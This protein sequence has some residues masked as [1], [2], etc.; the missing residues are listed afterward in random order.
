[1]MKEKIILYGLS[2]DIEDI[3][4][5]MRPCYQII[6][7]SDKN[8]K[9]GETIAKKLNTKY[10][11]PKDINNTLASH[12]CVT[13]M[14]AYGNIYHDLIYVYGVS[15]SK[16]FCYDD[17]Y[18][19]IEM[20]LGDLNPDKTI[21]IIRWPSCR[22]GF[23]A[24]LVAFFANLIDL[25]KE[26]DV[27][28]DFINYR[29]IY[30]KDAEIGKVNSFEKYFKQPCGLSA[31]EVY[32]SKH[33][34]LSGMLDKSAY[35][36]IDKNDDKR[37]K[38]FSDLIHKYLRPN[39]Q[40]EKILQAER[41]KIFKDSEKICAVIFRGT[42]YLLA[43]AYNHPIQPDIEMLIEKVKEL[44]NKWHFRKIYLSTE[45]AQGQQKF[46]EE[47]GDNVLFS[48]RELIDCYP[49]LPASSAVANICFDR[50]DDEYLKG[51]EYLRQVFVA[52]E[53]NYMISGIN[54]GFKGALLLSG[55]F[56][57]CFAFHL[58]L[59][60][61]DD[62]SYATPWGHYVLLKEEKEKEEMRKREKNGL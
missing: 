37:L 13:A 54:S 43:K 3:Y 61:I 6:G 25:P 55:G 50:K 26:Y 48:E 27:Y 18:R 23:F 34:I 35:V 7:I 30:M 46:I 15:R 52:A 58:V 51:V 57:E 16:V 9:K 2:E 22:S 38:K 60:G 32:N 59:Y 24:I 17:F 28:F 44:Q 19:E 56:E 29:N 49:V 4:Y 5:A 31:E 62:D 10:V 47:F 42:D 14:S 33:V 41:K 39:E 1:M 12:I 40:F 45:D 53:C 20:S 36:P 8:R 11:N 21:Y